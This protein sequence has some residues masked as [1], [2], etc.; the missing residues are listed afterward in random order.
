[1]IV[2]NNELVIR[3]L[4]KPREGWEAAFRAMGQAGDD[5]LVDSAES[6]VTSWDETEW[7]WK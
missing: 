7:E 4:H 2:H 6:S 1:M 5:R 3:S